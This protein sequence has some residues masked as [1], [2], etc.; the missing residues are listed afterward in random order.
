MKPYNNIS[1]IVNLCKYNNYEL[2]NS[3]LSRY[4]IAEWLYLLLYHEIKADRRRT[5][6]AKQFHRLLA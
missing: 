1:F 2:Q 3:V 4:E 5:L 6:L